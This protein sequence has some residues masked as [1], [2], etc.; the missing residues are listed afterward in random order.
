MSGYPA[1]S[2]FADEAIIIIIIIIII[3]WTIATDVLVAGC[4]CL[5]LTRLSPAKTAERIEVLFEVET[6]G[7]PR[8]TELRRRSYFLHIFDAA[9]AKLLHK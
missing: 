2:L 7:S 8:N 9:F 4:V 3:T 1:R 5:S 6:L